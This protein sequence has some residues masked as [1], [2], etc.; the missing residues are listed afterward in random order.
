MTTEEMLMQIAGTIAYAFMTG[1]IVAFW[2]AFFR[3][4]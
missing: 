1:M 2:I 3:K 4:K